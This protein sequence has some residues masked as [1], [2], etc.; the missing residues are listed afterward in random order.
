MGVVFLLL[1][2]VGALVLHYLYAWKPKN[3][4]KF[5]ITHPMWFAHRGALHMAPENTSAAY[6]Q[7]TEL[8][9]P[10]LEIDVVSTR[11][12]K[13]VCSHNFDLERE[14]DVFGYIHKLLFDELKNVN[15]GAKWSDCWEP[16]PL[17]EEVLHALPPGQRL[18]IEVKT[19]RIF[20]FRTALNVARLIRA[21]NLQDRSI[22]SSFNPF[23][24][25]AVKWVDPSIL[26]GFILETMGYFWLLNLVH[27][28]CLHPVAELVHD[29]LLKFARDRGLAVNVWTVNTRPAICWLVERGVDGII[30]DRPEYVLS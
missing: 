29:D 2:L 6:E 27:P 25:W 21:K 9:M 15:A 11:D 26:T 18:N 12:G 17:L 8:G 13:L 20:D 1:V 30:T 23:A 22:V 7:A 28:D 14:T 10:A 5:Y 16:L 3:W 24:I 4:K 19:Y